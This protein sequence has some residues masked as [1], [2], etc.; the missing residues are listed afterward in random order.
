MILAIF[1]WIFLCML[2]QSKYIE[3]NNEGNNNSSCCIEGIC[4]CGSLYEAL[5]HIENN[6]VINI[7]SSIPLLNIT[8][9]ELLNNITIIGN[10]IT[11][12]CNNTGVFTCWHCS[13]VVIQGIT[14]DQCG[15]PNHPYYN[16]EA[17]SFTNAVN[18]SIVR[19]T[20]Q[21]SKVCF[22]VYF[23]LSSGFLEMHDN[24]F[25]FNHI[26]D[27]SRCKGFYGSLFIFDG[28]YDTVQSLYIFISG[29]LFYRNG[30]S[31]YTTQYDSIPTTASLVC[32]LSTQQV[33]ILI[34]NSILS[35][36]YGLGSSVIL[37]D[38]S[39][40]VMQFTNVT[41]SNNSNG[42]S[43]ILLFGE[44]LEVYFSANSC[45]YENNIN[46]S[47]KLSIYAYKSTISLYSLKVIEN[48]GSFV[49]SI[50]AFGQRSSILLTSYCHFVSI[51]DILYCNIQG[52]NGG[53]SIVY[54]EDISN[55]QMV[56][57]VSSNF[58]NNFVS[59][60]HVS[61]CTVE[62]GGSV[63]FQN[64]SARKGG[65]M[66][67]DKGSHIAIKENSTV[68][69]NRNTALQEGGAIYMELSFDCIV[70]LSNTSHILFAN[71]SAEL[72]DSIYLSNPEFCD[73]LKKSLGSHIS[74]SPY[75]INL[76]STTCDDSKSTCH[77]PNRNMLGQP[78]GIN[79]TVCDYYGDISELVL[80]LYVECTNCNNTIMLRNNRILVHNGLFYITFVAVNEDSDIAN[81]TNITLSLSSV[82]D[83]KYEQLTTEFSLE[84]SS[85][86]GGYIFAENYNKEYECKC[87]EESEDII[88]CQKGYAEIKHGYWFGIAPSPK[89]KVT[90]SSCPINYCDYRMDAETNNGYYKLPEEMNDQCNSYRTGVACG[91]CK[92]GYTLTYD[93]PNCVNTDS[94]SAGMTTLVVTLTIIYW[95]IVVALVFC[96]M[97]CKP[98]LG[99]A[100][101]IIYYYSV[102]DILLGSNLYISDGV[103]QLVTILSSFAKLSPQFLGRL[104]FV[105]GL[106]GID[107]QFIHYFHAVSI[108]FLI[109]GIVIAARH[110]HRVASLVSR[111][112]IR[113]ICLLILLSYTSLTSTSLQLL[114]PLYFK[115]LGIYVYSSPSIKYFTGRHILYGVIALLCGLFIVI[116]IPLLLLLEPFLKRKINFIR[117]KPLL[118]QYQQ[119]YK[120]RYHWF[121]AYYLVCRLVIFAIVYI[122]NFIH[123]LYYLQTICIIIV[124]FHIW[125]KPY[126]SEL[127]NV[128]DAILLLTIVLVVNL[129]S[130]A[131]SRSSTITIV[132]ITVIFPLVL[133]CL[134]YCK[135]FFS[136]KKCTRIK[137]TDNKSK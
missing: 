74:T 81:N 29:T 1:G 103:F 87:Y 52:N 85:C 27:F 26:T 43:V 118:D 34:E 30:V 38:T 61:Y 24:Q 133:S 32:F 126:K 135:D 48:K 55:H 89:R 31:G 45:S 79:A 108:F 134:T 50:S 106:S 59:A 41:F 94:C 130:F 92:S 137:K 99:Y 4:L 22:V 33:T 5:L 93:S 53:K 13:N 114:R 98:S 70:N 100:Y 117:I 86:H 76:C 132:V 40:V 15:N 72:G 128:L 69:F 95:I 19:C 58:T 66:Y 12:E 80:H 97:Q 112:I 110:S 17:F 104:C 44:F 116:G 11:V 83:H 113:V 10:T 28:E 47:L 6:T 82:L 20:F 21:Y 120:D 127:L 67:V 75:T 23:A 115:K 42:G 131:F 56:S 125:I 46:G 68:T 123:S 107:Q 121:A 73:D 96:L 36:S 84:L 88:R 90:V 51:I 71:N 136:S 102:I 62:F 122:S 91:E 37:F 124:S 78:I 18:I 111:C 57:I 14:W 8:N 77:V 2:C 64:N 101:G 7:T 49:D 3:V 54:I 63:L 129:A 35:A 16:V 25:L 39:N 119:C 105:E 60:L 65:A 109:V 9:V